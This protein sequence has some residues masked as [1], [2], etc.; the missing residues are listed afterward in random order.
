MK[1][2]VVG[3]LVSMWVGFATPPCAVNA[4]EIKALSTG[5]MFSILGE[6]TGEFERTTGH[7]LIIE[8]GSTTRM[9]SRVEADEAADITINEKFVLEDLLHQARIANGTIVDIARS[10][11]AIGV[12]IGAPKPDVSSVDGLKRVLLAADSIV[13]PDP[14]G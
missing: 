6:I 14:S 13:H 5:N 9:K 8:Y 7:K 4:A 1:R 11:L 12:R 3:L 2:A 10:P